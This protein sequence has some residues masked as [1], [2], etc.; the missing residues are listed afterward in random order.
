MADIFIVTATSDND[1]FN[2]TLSEAINL[3]KVD[4]NGAIIEF[5]SVVFTGNNTYTLT[6]NLP[7]LGIA[8]N[9][10]IDGATTS[11]V[12]IT[13]DAAGYRGL[14]VAS[15]N[16]SLSDLTIAN[17]AAVGA[18][19]QNAPSGGGAGGGGGGAGL[20]GGLFVSAGASVTLNNVSFV[21]DSATGGAGGDGTSAS[22]N[23]GSGGAGGG[24]A[25]TAGGFGGDHGGVGEGGDGRF[26]AGGGGGGGAVYQHADVNGDSVIIGG[27]GSGGTSEFLPV[28]IKAGAIA[29]NVPL[30]DLWI[31]PN[32]AMYLSGVLI[33]AKDLINGV[34]IVQEQAVDTLEYFHVELD[35][36][37]VILAEGALS[38]SFID[39]DSRGMFHN[40][41]EYETL[42]AEEPPAPTSYCAPR[43]DEGYEV[44]AVRQRLAARTGLARSTEA[45]QLGALRGH[46]DRI[47]TGGISGWAQNADAPEA[48]VCLDIYAAGKPIGRVLANAYRDDLKRAGLGSGRHAFT[49]TPPAGIPLDPNAIEVRRALDGAVL[50]P[51]RIKVHR[52]AS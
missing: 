34:S 3:A 24:F 30:R 14:F 2:L 47:R 32:H 16:I 37:D 40:A 41:H 22:P 19:G 49:F 4:R 33:E 45:L 11:G 28:C 7:E 42:F 13:I 23:A 35:T 29:D 8:A 31:S 15:G 20:G 26:G 46:I 17:A 5:S 43:L 9:I 48:P 18:A 10:T 51:P 21:N 50:D 52:R 6:G 39:D 1:P 25:G 36:H 38:E 44:E 27:A 12:D